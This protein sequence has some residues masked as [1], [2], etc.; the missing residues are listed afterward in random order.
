[1]WTRFNFESVGLKIVVV[2]AGGI[3]GFLGG[4]LAKSGEDVTVIARGDHLQTIREKGLTVESV[5]SGNFTC[6]VKATEKPSDA[7]AANLVLFCV[8]SYDTEKALQN[9]SP[10][11]GEDTTVI[12]F[13]N[14]IDKE[15]KIAQKV[16]KGHVLAGAIFIE[17]FITQP[18]VIKQTWGPL[19]AIGE[20]DGTITSRARKIHTALTNAGLKCDLSNR[21][22]EALWEKFLFI[23]PTAGI[24]S[25][26]RATIGEIVEFEKTSAL[27]L[28]AME[29]V[30]R[31]AR[32]TGISL[33]SDI[34]QRTFAQAGRADKSMKPSMLRDLERGKR[35]EIDALN[36]SVCRYGRQLSVPTPVNDFIYA[37]LKVQDMKAARALQN[38]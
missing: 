10:L 24:C 8:K 11:I 23:C 27:Y 29:E 21:I 34:V 28:A 5:S 19:I 17:S 15:D 9:I 13:Q 14:G 38:S 36:G 20:L 32:A 3:G 31:V 37:L 35:L 16:G 1:M 30:E 4:T 6:S 25:A 18:G 26:A 7:G 22:L 33:A 2:G 12:S